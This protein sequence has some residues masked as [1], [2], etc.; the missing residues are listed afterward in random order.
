ML[1]SFA[2][3]TAPARA[4]LMC[5][6]ATT[7]TSLPSKSKVDPT[8]KSLVDSIQVLHGEQV[9]AAAEAGDHPERRP[10][11]D[12]GVAEGLAAREEVGEVD[13]DDGHV[14]RSQAVIEGVGVVAQRGRVDD[15]AQ[16]ARRLLL[17][18]VDQLALAVALEEADLP[19]QLLGARVDHRL[20]GGQRP[21][22]VDLGLAGSQRIEV[23]A[24]GDDHPSGCAH[25]L[26]ISTTASRTAA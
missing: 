2:L 26:S 5:S 23:G 4:I 10:G 15:H 20:D 11:G 25:A 19:A 3:I 8:R 14:E 17:E 9:A 1:R 21:A 18:A 13:L 22:A 24:V 12:A 16:R 7:L 6:T